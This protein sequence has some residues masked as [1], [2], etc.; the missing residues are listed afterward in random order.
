MSSLVLAPEYQPF[1]KQTAFHR[2]S[3]RFKV[4]AAGNRGGKTLSGAAEFVANIYRDLKAGK[5]KAS[6]RVGSTR[7]P[8]LAYWIITPTHEMGE[9]PYRELVRFLPR[10][11][12]E[13]VNASTREI[14][15]RGDIQIDFKSTERPERLVAA[16]LNGLWMD[17]ACRC[18][19]EAWRG[20]LRARLADQQGWALFTTSPLGGKNNWVYQELVAREGIDEHIGSFHWRTD[21]NPHI[22]STEIE[23]A[24]A[25]TAPQ[26]FKRD[27][28]ASWDAFG[29]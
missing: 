11:L 1:T 18:K 9:F 20:G 22:P 27:W 12:I 8:R 14:W 10:E 25:N 23:H 24:R 15:L 7:V 19:A 29:G 16:S 2:S 3:K 17:E 13:K 5:G 28:E 26:W 21:E 6:V 4:A